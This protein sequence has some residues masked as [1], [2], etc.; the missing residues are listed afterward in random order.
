MTAE[1]F[2]DIT[3]LVAAILLPATVL[4]ATVFTVLTHYW[5]CNPGYVWWRKRE[6]LTDLMYWFFVPLI[7]A[8]LFVLAVERGW[9]APFGLA[10]NAWGKFSGN[11]TTEFLGDGR[12]MRLL[13]EVPRL[14]QPSAVRYTCLNVGEEGAFRQQ[15]C[16]IDQRGALIRLA[17]QYLRKR[18]LRFARCRLHRL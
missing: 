17:S 5:A 10:P 18:P 15:C 14:L 6:L 2:A 11:P 8:G 1:P 16:Q 3:G 7:L 9:L 12:N 13:E 4:L